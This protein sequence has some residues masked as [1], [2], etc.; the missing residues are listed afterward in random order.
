MEGFI[1]G[2][3]IKEECDKVKDCECCGL[4]NSTRLLLTKKGVGMVLSHLCEICIDE[5]SDYSK[6]YDYFVIKNK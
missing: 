1:S 6:D 5:I 3:I 2:T 4:T